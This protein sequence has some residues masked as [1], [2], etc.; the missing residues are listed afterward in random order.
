MADC[1]LQG[2]AFPRSAATLRLMGSL[3]LPVRFCCFLFK[4]P[5]FDRLAY[6]SSVLNCFFLLRM[7]CFPFFGC[8]VR[9]IAHWFVE[10]PY[11]TS[12]TSFFGTFYPPSSFSFVVVDFSNT[13]IEASFHRLFPFS[14]QREY[15]I[16]LLP[17][18]SRFILWNRKEL[19][20]GMIIS[21]TY[22]I[23]PLR[24]I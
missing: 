1:N 4:D 6:G 9:K 14:E 7:S 13:S 23:L 16:V 2:V 10:L 19:R 21:H 12:L 18:V 20:K 24:L 8:S 22:L 3:L 17:S 11:S 5:N 15:N